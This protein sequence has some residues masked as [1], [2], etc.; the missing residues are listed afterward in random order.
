[1]KWKHG[2]RHRN[3]CLC[4]FRPEKIKNKISKTGDISTIDVFDSG[5]GGLFILKKLHKTFP[6]KSFVYLADKAHFPYGEKSSSFIHSA[7]RKNVQI[8]ADAVPPHPQ[9]TS[10]IFH[11]IYKLKNMPKV[12]LELTRFV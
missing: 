5:L 4:G 10:L 9:K 8:L 11:Y 3:Q 7:I 12:R 1:M 6:E 2:W